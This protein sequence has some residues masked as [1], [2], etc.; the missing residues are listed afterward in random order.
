MDYLNDVMLVVIVLNCF[1]FGVCVDEVFFV[2]LKVVL[3]V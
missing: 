2:D 3:F 1:G